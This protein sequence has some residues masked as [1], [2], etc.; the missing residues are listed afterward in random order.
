MPPMGDLSSSVYGDE[1]LFLDIESWGQGLQG[2]QNTFNDASPHDGFGCDLQPR[3]H[4]QLPPLAGHHA[5]LPPIRPRSFHNTPQILSRTADHQNTSSPLP[6]I[7]NHPIPGIHTAEDSHADSDSFAFTGDSLN[8]L[9]QGIG[10]LAQNHRDESGED[11]GFSS[12]SDSTAHPRPT[13]HSSPI[14]VNY[15]SQPLPITPTFNDFVDLTDDISPRPRRMSSSGNS[16]GAKR[17]RIET[18][19]ERASLN[20]RDAT[21]STTTPR[22]PTDKAIAEVDLI[23]VDNDQGL[24]KLL[25]DQRQATIRAQ[26][27][28]ASR[29]NKLSGIQCIICMDTMANVTA[30]S[31][32]ILQIKSA[33]YI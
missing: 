3:I 14:Q 33:K 11:W 1:D 26:Q 7:S 10:P 5:P 29:P 15:H 20:I 2:D 27:E 18:P 9:Q 13:F 6:R 19:G 21:E 31:C 24:S 4:D 22:L 12:E 8:A 17:R 28:Q 25:E 30:T 23:D 32:G 16:R